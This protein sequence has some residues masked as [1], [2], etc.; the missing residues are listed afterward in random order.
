[1]AAPVLLV[2]AAVKVLGFVIVAAVLVAGAL[3]VLDRDPA[4]P[5][6]RHVAIAPAES[7]P[8]AGGRVAGTTLT[9]QQ[10]ADAAIEDGRKPDLVPLS[11]HDFDEPIAEA[12]APRQP[13]HAV[14]GDRS[15]VRTPVRIAAAQVD[16][17]V[18]SPRVVVAAGD[19]PSRGPGRPRDRDAWEGSDPA[20]RCLAAVRIVGHRVAT[21]VGSAVRTPQ[22][23]AETRAR[24]PAVDDDHR[25]DSRELAPVD[26][27]DDA[28]LGAGEG[29][30]WIE[31]ERDSERRPVAERREER[32]R[33]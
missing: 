3:F 32:R 18:E 4:P 12:E 28:G 8:G 10:A 23:L 20:A 15:K 5:Q 27:G 29:Q 31:R 22:A 16:D 17:D 6:V 7:S 21:P 14:V 25:H 11:E 30:I 2:S 33:P 26:V 1:M 19:R 9:A 24:P 13:E